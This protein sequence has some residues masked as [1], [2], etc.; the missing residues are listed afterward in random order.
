[1]PAERPPAHVPP[2]AD[3]AA[4][5]RHSDDAII[6]KTPEGLITSWNAG[7]QR[8]YG[9]SAAEIVG[10]PV[11]VLIPAGRLHEE[12]QILATIRAGSRVVH[13]DTERLRKDGTVVRVSLTVS[14]ILDDAGRVVGASSISRDATLRVEAQDLFGDLLEALPDAMVI[15]GPDGAIVLVNSQT[16]S[17]FGYGR[18]ELVGR[19]VEVII[20]SDLH[21]RHRAHRA[22]FFADPRA[23]PMGRGLQLHGRRRDGTQFPVEVSLSPLHAEAGL[24]VSAAIRDVSERKA[25]EALVVEALDRER[26]VTDRLREL[27]RLKDEFLAAVSH[28]LRT[29]L[30][31]IVG[32]AELLAASEN[33]DLARR[34]YLLDRI[35]SNSSD[36]AAMVEQLLDYSRLQAD[37]VSINVRP[38]ALAEALSSAVTAVSGSLAEHELDVADSPEARVMVDRPAFD[39]VLGNLLTNAAKFSPAGSTIRVRAR[40]HDREAVV[41]VSDEGT[42]IDAANQA[43]VFERFFQGVPAMVGKRGTGLGLAIARQYVEMMGGRIW[44]H[45]QPGQGSTFFFTLPRAGAEQAG[46]RKAGAP[47]A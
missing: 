45:S 27:D 22:A 4:I 29:P 9:H 37:R 38:V 5:V 13:Y 40:L 35:V 23:R 2:D 46:A 25:A 36:M 41:E 39:R 30:T 21:E 26:R 3:L 43:R 6:G 7:A 15:A 16:E 34:Q 47:E 32:F 14:P 42:G 10:R 12:R 1:M 17:L 24:L 33:V 20:P 31:A 28:E 44:V 8:L 19:P 11:D 18:D